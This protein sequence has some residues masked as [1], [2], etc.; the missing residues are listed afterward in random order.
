MIEMVRIC[1]NDDI[2]ISDILTIL[3]KI[4]SLNSKVTG[5]NVVSGTIIIPATDISQLQ[6][7]VRDINKLVLK[8][9]ITINRGKE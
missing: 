8:S 4:R 7:M 2:L 9:I 5:R 6:I 1:I 3:G